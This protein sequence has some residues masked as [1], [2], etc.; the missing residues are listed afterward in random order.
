MVIQLKGEREL[1][2]FNIE[3][4]RMWDMEL[5]YVASGWERPLGPT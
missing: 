5:G 1:I 2:Y 3:K 4:F